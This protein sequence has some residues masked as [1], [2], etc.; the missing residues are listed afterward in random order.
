M[1]PQSGLP[2]PGNNMPPQ[3]QPG[4][5]AEWCKPLTRH[6]RKLGLF[7]P[8]GGEGT[9]LDHLTALVMGRY[10]VTIPPEGSVAISYTAA[11]DLIAK[12]R[13]EELYSWILERY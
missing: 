7:F 12:N 13:E 4:N 8:I 9:T 11:R 1:P 2:L 6:G 5:S 10:G 3:I